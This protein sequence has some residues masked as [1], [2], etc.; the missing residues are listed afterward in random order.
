MARL[1]KRRSLGLQS[2]PLAAVAVVKGTMIMLNSAGFATTAVAAASN[3][4][5][6]GVATESVDNSGGS[7]GDLEVVVEEG[8]FT[9]TAVGAAQADVLTQAFASSGTTVSGTQATNEPAAGVIRR[10]RSA[11]SVDVE[12][13]AFAGR[14]VS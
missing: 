4:G 12:I 10:F 7:A 11:T 13:S 3:K 9:V 8:I 5:V 6:V 1:Q 2:Y 14:A